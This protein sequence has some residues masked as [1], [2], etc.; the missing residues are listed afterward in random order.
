MRE[1]KIQI[2]KMVEEGKITTEEGIEL[3]EALE[4]REETESPNLDSP[5]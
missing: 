3:L 4:T 1:E 5:K 2:L